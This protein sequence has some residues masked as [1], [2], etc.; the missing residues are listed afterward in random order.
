MPTTSVGARVSTNVVEIRRLALDGLVEIVPKRFSDERGFF[1]EVWRDDWVAELGA[2]V[3]FVQDNHSYSRF[4]GVVRG[5]HYQ[6][7]PAAQ[8]KLVRVVRGAIFDA[9]VDIRRDSPTFA[10][11]TGVQL[12]AD[13]WN[14]L[15]VPEGFA[16]GFMTLE[17]HTEVLYKVSAAYE[18]T[19][20]RGIRFDD[21]AIGIQWP[22]GIDPILSAKDVAAPLLAEAEL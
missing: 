11:W 6:K 2:E 22:I 3:R 8:A 10:Q 21:P 20:D 7:P 9:V 4:R 5:L 16:H 12:S 13:K 17:D 15:Y 1:S 18:P 14:Q 19:L